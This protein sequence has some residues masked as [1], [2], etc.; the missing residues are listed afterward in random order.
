[1][2]RLMAIVVA[3]ITLVAGGLAQARQDPDVVKRVVE[4]F[5]RVQ[6]QGLP[7]EVS[8]LVGAIDPNNTLQP[9]PALE[10]FMPPGARSWG[11]TTVGVRCRIEEGWRIFVSARVRVVAEVMVAARPLTAGTIL[12]DAD[13]ASHPGDLGEMP[14]GVVTE[15]A[16]AIGQSLTIGVPAGRPLRGDLMRAPLLVQQGQTVKVIS[17]GAGFQVATD[18]RALTSAAAG[19][20]A[21][22]RTLSG[23]M[24]SGVTRRPGVVE[25]AF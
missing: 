21:Q 10:A 20:I 12:S 23:Q 16:Q 25:V 13:L 24:V 17:R 8:F 14:A 6:T 9:C 7:G 19:Q 3:A 2:Q 4:D 18:G 22:V 5:L 1:M 11:R 15:R